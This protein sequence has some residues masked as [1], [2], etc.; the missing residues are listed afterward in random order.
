MKNSATGNICSVRWLFYK[1]LLFTLFFFNF[2]T[3]KAQQYTENFVT[4]PAFTPYP[5]Y[6][7]WIQ[8]ATV[9]LGG[10]VYEFDNG[11]NGGWAYNT[12]GGVNNSANLLYS[13]DSIAS[14]TIKRED[15][16]RFQFYGAWLKYTNFDGGY[17]PPWL[18]VTYNGSLLADETYNE[19]TTV[20]LNQSV[21]VTSVT[22]NFSGLI[23]L[24]FDSITV[25]PVIPV[26][27]FSLSTDEISLFTNNSA[28]LNGSV[29]D[30]GGA[31][32]SES[33]IVYGTLAAPTIADNKLA[34]S[35]GVSAFSHEVTGLQS[36]MTY[37]FRSYAINSAGISYGN[38][39]SVTTFGTFTMAGAHNFNTE[40]V[41]SYYQISPF[42][43]YIE[44]WDATGESTD[45]GV[46]STW[47]LTDLDAG[48]GVAS[49][50]M[51]DDTYGELM[52]MSMKPHD[53]SVF[54]LQSFIFRYDVQVAGTSFGT[55]TVKGYKNRVAVPG[56]I[57]TILNVAPISIEASY[58]TF[59]PNANAFD[60]IDEFR[61]TAS[62]SPD[63]AMLYNFDI[64][65]ITTTTGGA[66][67]V[68]FTS[69]K[70]YQKNSGIQ[71][72]WNVSTEN[73]VNHYEIEKSQN[74]QQFE[75][76]GDISP[77][78]NNYSSQSY[79]WF[80]PNAGSGNNYYRIKSV[81]NTGSI[82]YSLVVNVAIVG[83][84]ESI[85][86]YPNPVTGSAIILQ[87]NN[88]PKGLYTVQLFSNAGQQ[89]YNKTLEHAG[90]SSTQTLEL[91][92]I[93]EKG[94][95]QLK[96]SGISKSYTQKGY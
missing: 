13:T 37:Y 85:S 57:Q 78:A 92:N 24:N 60:G 35:S 74:G 30:D 10:T 1:P 65:A 68:M 9:T 96:V 11:A 19:N 15:G 14:V 87:L 51:S 12:T 27:P 82:S 72:D 41:S 31:I 94:I 8:K 50:R 89:L 5:P 64:D 90:G 80:D 61:L 56:A 42:T 52:Y 70:A 62:N 4:T 20:I 91:K 58:N 69:V 33:G 23:D 38:E 32:V 84:K 54:N 21:N 86:V 22:L 76:A 75:K 88:Q 83:G 7:A 59:T 28:T 48:E 77:K 66:L 63:A 2:I 71:V 18:T 53:S 29:T 36:G 17:L 44:G 34:L 26:A 93:F 81:C 49:I 45:V 43:K 67:A 40:W 39:V 95:Y 47:R 6:P 73:S 3:V 25:G 55:I 79:K 16:Q 46:I